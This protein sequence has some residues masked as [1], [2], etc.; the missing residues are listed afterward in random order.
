MIDAIPSQAVDRL[1]TPPTLNRMQL[2]KQAEDYML[3]HLDQSI[4]LKEVCEAIHVSSRP[5]DCLTE[6]GER[7]EIS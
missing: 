4:T 2:V 6:V 7:L 1:K 5:P 3:A